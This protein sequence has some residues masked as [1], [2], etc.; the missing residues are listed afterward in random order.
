MGVCRRVPLP[1][2]PAWTGKVQPE[3]SYES[4]V[5]F[6]FQAVARSAGL[7]NLSMVACSEVR[8]RR[9]AFLLSFSTRPEM[10]IYFGS[11]LLRVSKPSGHFQCPAA[12]LAV[13]GPGRPRVARIGKVRI[14][15]YGRLRRAADMAGGPV[16]SHICEIA[17]P[18]AVSLRCEIAPMSRSVAAPLTSLTR[19]AADEERR[20]QSQRPMETRVLSGL[21]L[22]CEPLW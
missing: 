16:L 14:L 6:E 10:N 2:V 7:R 13:W 22:R 4:F 18:P 5:R 21:R 3:S 12:P 11:Q 8:L 20:A 15:R 17:G 19:H 9:N 1:R